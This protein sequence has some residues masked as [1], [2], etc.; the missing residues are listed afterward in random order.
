[1]R[2]IPLQLLRTNDEAS[3]VELVGQTGQVQ[4]LAEMGLREGVAV[5]MVRPG[6]PC[7]LALDGKRLSLRLSSDVNVLVACPAG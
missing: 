4:R 2:A 3:V 6:H 5:R 7:L 1:M